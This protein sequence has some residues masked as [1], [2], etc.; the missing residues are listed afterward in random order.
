MGVT[1]LSNGAL[2]LSLLFGWFY[3]WTVAPNWQ[4]PEAPVVNHWLLLGSAVLLSMATPW[5]RRVL[6]RLRLGN[7]RGLL[8][9]QLGLTVI[10]LVQGAL[11][12]VALLSETLEPTA[13]AH[14]AVI[15]VM[16][17]YSLGHALLASILSALQALR[18]RIGYVGAESPYEPLVVAQLWAYNL[19]VLWISYFAIALFPPAFGGA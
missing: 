12:L 18:I 15:F 9:C 10:G 1:L 19:G 16:L 17:A 13:R 8:A 14:D 7:A 4:V 2:Y 11:L 3:L 5:H 6:A